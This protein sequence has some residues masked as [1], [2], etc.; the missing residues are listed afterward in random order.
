MDP[1]WYE[2]MDGTLAFMEGMVPVYRQIPEIKAILWFQLNSTAGKW[3]TGEMG[4]YVNGEP[5][6]LGQRYAELIEEAHGGF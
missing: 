1:A 3:S 6:V 4:L 2:G 5:T